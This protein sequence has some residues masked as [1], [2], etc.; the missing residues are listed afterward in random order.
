MNKPQILDFI[1]LQSLAVLST[2][3]EDGRP[4]AAVIGF[5]QTDDF[6]LLFGTDDFS[7]KYRNMQANPA[8]ALVI[9]GESGQTVQYEGVAEELSRDDLQ[10]VRDNYWRK[11]PLAEK[12]D[13]NDSQR[14]FI[15]R[16]K[17]LRYTDLK[18]TP[19]E[20]VELEF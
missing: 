5:G 16:P 10:L 7:R 6:E 1:K 14:Y 9:G 3:G 15:V 11:T 20:I 8:V 17:W 13:A 12:Y 19:R 18:K 2:I 4:Q